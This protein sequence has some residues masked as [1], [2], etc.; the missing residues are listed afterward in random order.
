MYRILIV[1]DEAITRKG[2]SNH[3]HWDKLNIEEIHTASGAREALTYMEN[4]HVDIVLSDVRMPGM[5]GI[6]MCGEI[7]KIAPD[8]QVIFLSGYSDK[9]Y[10]KGAIALEAVSY[11]EKPISIPEVETAIK[12]AIAKVESNREKNQSVLKVVEENR[13]YLVAGFLQKLMNGKLDI[14]EVKKNMELLELDWTKNNRFNIAIFKAGVEL[15]ELEAVGEKI[16]KVTAAVEHIFYIKESKYIV[17]LFAY[18]E[19]EKEK[20]NFVYSE[21]ANLAKNDEQIKLSGSFGCTVSNIMNIQK[22]YASAVVLMQQLFFYG[23]GK[24]NHY[25]SETSKD[26][27]VS[28]NEEAISDFMEAIDHFD[29]ASAEQLA[30]DLYEK[31]KENPNVLVSHVKGLYFR[32]IDIVLKAAEHS[33]SEAE[34][35]GDTE[36]IAFI[37][38]KLNTLENVSECNKYL[39]EE[40][41]EY[42]EHTKD[43]ASNSKIV[44]EIMEYVKKNYM[45]SALCLNE[46]AENV[47]ITPNYMNSL[48]KKKFGKTVGQYI[49]DV[50]IQ[51][52]K[53]LIMDRKIKLSDVAEM[54]GY[55]DA[56]YFTKVF[57]KNVGISPK[58]YR[59]R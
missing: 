58:D 4:N 20:M 39:T 50:R 14:T 43:L 13:N 32:F 5:N 41:K 45:N 25:M 24:I 35:V 52:A 8:C 51:M 48:F 11:V 53:E 21:V 2:L 9:E 12:K 40:I 54:V 31:A 47:Y 29:S 34:R 56:G 22:S 36:R 42:F 1:D 3:V 16:S 28:V 33:K 30:M 19:R 10:L 7:K 6:E 57:R 49:T 15:I 38:E 37:W 23:Y 17:F 44:I 59:E 46:I 27:T 55:N 18:T 26:D